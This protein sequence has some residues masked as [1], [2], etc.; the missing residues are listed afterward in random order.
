MK[1]PALFFCLKRP[2]FLK[3]FDFKSASISLKYAF[4]CSSFA[5]HDLLAAVVDSLS[6]AYALRSPTGVSN[7]AVLKLFVH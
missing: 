5:K 1:T 4:L 7:L 6:L 3:L 2:G